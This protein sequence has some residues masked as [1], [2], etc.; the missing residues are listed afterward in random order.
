MR[1]GHLLRTQAFRIVMVYVLLFALS[2]AALLGFT[3]WNTRRVL[4]EQTDQ[5][6]E[7]D[8]TGLQEQYARLGV[9][10]LAETVRSRSLHLGQTLYLLSDGLHHSIA[11][12]LDSWPEVT[13][14]TGNFVEFDYERRVSGPAETRRA[15]GALFPLQTPS[16]DFY[17]LVAEDVEAGSLVAGND[18]GC[19]AHQEGRVANSVSFANGR[20]AAADVS[21]RLELGIYSPVGESGTHQ[22]RPGLFL[23]CSFWKSSNRMNV[24]W[25]SKAVMTAPR[26]WRRPMP[27]SRLGYW[28]ASWPLFASQVVPNSLMSG[29]Q[30]T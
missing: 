12:N 13:P 26:L 20:H 9:M 19:D 7:A 1:S 3:Y 23:F 25:P 10:G 30:W 4:D 16:G 11:G 28:L 6:I 21:R 17:L 18:F 24:T 14:Q 5:I 27:S 8:I 22:R 29:S 2:V 15:R